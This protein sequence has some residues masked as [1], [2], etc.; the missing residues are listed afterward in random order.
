[1]KYIQS[2]KNEQ[3]KYLNKLLLSAKTR[4]QHHLCALEGIHLLKSYLQQGLM[5]KQ[6]FIPES[7][8]TH[9]EL[10]AIIHTLPSDLITFVGHDHLSKISTLND[11]HDIISEIAI[12]Q[13]ASVPIQGDCIIL[14]RIQDP[15]NVGTILRSAAAANIKH[16][17]LSNDCADVWSPKVLRAGMGAHFNLNIYTNIDLISW[18]ANYK[19]QILATTLTTTCCF[20]LYEMNLQSPQAWLFGNEGNG[21]S[22]TLLAQA[23]AAVR[24]PMNAQVESLNVAMATTICLFEQQRQ[25]QFSYPNQAK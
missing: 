22:T 19:G 3:L 24:I 12:P 13:Y 4:H 18:C 9:P 5:P 11:S 2:S 6:I 14:E 20:S 21:I 23:H 17:I 1:M 16:I 10:Q 15:G 25:R 7:R 8:S